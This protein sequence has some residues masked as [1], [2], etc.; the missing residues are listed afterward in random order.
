LQRGLEIS[1]LRCEYLSGPIGLQVSKPRLSW[2]L[3][4]EGDRGKRQTA[5][6]LLVSDNPD[7]LRNNLGNFWDTEKV[8]S[9]NS[10][11]VEYNGKKLNSGSCYYWKVRVWDERDSP[12]DFSQVASWEMGLLNSDDWGAKWVEG[13]NLL[14]TEFDLAGPPVKARAYVSSLCYYELRINGEKIGDRVLDPAPSDTS[15]RV[16]YAVFDITSVLRVGRNAIGLMLGEKKEGWHKAIVQL[17]FEDERGIKKL[18]GSDEIW[19]TTEEGP[20]VSSDLYD[21]ETYDARLEK[22][23][24]DCP[25][26]PERWK[27]CKLASV[28]GVGKLVSSSFFPPIRVVKSLRPSQVTESFPGVYIFDFGQNFSGWAK[29]RVEGPIGTEVTME[30]AELLNPDGTLNQGTNRAAKATDVYILKG[31]GVEEYEPRFTYHGFRY[32]KVCGFPG[33][34]TM[35][36]LEGRF[37][38]TDV[39]SSGSFLCSDDLLNSIHRNTVWS[40]LSNL[41]GIP[42]DSPQRNE[43]LGWLQDAMLSAEVATM[44]FWMPGFFEK[45]LDDILDS[46]LEDGAIPDV[47]PSFGERY[48][49]DSSCG[50]TYIAIAWT[51]YELYGDR[52]ALEN[53]Y[54]GMKKWVEFEIS[55]SKDFILNLSKYWDWCAP[56][57]VKPVETPGELISTFWFHQNC[58]RLAEIARV[59]SNLEDY[60]RYSRLSDRIGEAFN[61][62][63]LAEREDRNYAHAERYSKFWG[64]GLSQTCNLLPLQAGIVPENKLGQVIDGLIQDIE[65]THDGHLNTGII[66][67]RFFFHILTKYGYGELAFKVA[68]QTTYPSY[69]YM[70]REGATTLWERWEYLGGVGMNSHNHIMFGAI[71]GWFYNVLGGIQ[72][73][74]SSVACGHFWIRPL[75]PKNLRFSTSSLE[76]VRGTLRSEWRKNK[77]NGKHSLSLLVQVPSNSG[78]T[79]C[80]PKLGHERVKLDEGSTVIFEDG[81]SIVLERNGIGSVKDCGHYLEC[82]IGSGSY[83]FRLH[84]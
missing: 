62:K 75:V 14:R 8:I 53:H 71:D 26:F 84:E 13:N 56:G 74:P 59:L 67:T 48:P 69:G 24:W 42:T 82:E 36:T 23:G 54:L 61:R 68:R 47:V 17:I 19:E 70:I 39:E 44:N 2:I 79:I 4:S 45:L 22:N 34:P 76:T 32:V 51:V 15:K 30:F 7:K 18:V 3:R 27:R 6:Q 57:H 78:A 10:V 65:I 83:E 31:S 21:G 77:E 37:V 49:A 80:I 72:P 29:L 43:R 25:N 66:G 73:D 50:A 46:Q 35:E 9:D 11:S 41:M 55:K 12:S 28:S 81:T 52:R 38:H 16:Y 40:Q 5:Y 64:Y 58:S 20:I 63:F 1:N 60:E 33:V